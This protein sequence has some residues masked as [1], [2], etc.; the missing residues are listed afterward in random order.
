MINNEE[1]YISFG[2]QEKYNTVV[3]T[4]TN[5]E[6]KSCNVKEEIRLVVFRVLFLY[7]VIL[8]LMKSTTNM[9]S[10]VVEEFVMSLVAD[11]HK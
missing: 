9:I 3:D 7:L 6:G 5:K 11:R 10:L 2:F 8:F 1:K 4:F